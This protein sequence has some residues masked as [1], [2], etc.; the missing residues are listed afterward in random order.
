MY[1]LDQQMNSLI[2]GY[3]NTDIYKTY[4]MCRE[5]LSQ[6]AQLKQ[7]VDEFRTKNFELQN[8]PNDGSLEERVQQFSDSYAWLTN[9]PLVR[10]FLDA[11]LAF[12]RMIQET[13]DYILEQL[14]FD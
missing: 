5:E 4:Q 14:D 8:Q 10:K 2:D 7:Q 1:N 3:K 6:D 12:C 9:Q 13:T 11:E